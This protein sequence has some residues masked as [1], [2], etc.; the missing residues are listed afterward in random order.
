MKITIQFDHPSPAKKWALLAF[1]SLA[2]LL[3]GGAVAWASGLHVWGTG[4][5]LSATD[6]NGNF[7]YLN[8]QITLLEKQLP[9]PSAF[10][11]EI[12]VAPTTVPTN[13]G[14][15]LLFDSTKFDLNAEYT[16]ATGTFSPKQAGVYFVQC[17]VDWGPTVPTTTYSVAIYDN[18]SEI[19]SS[20]VASAVAGTNNNGDLETPAN[21]IVKLAAGDTVQCATY[22]S[23]GA[24]VT[25]N[26]YSS[27]R[28]FFA[29]SR[30]F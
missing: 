2:L 12:T 21:G 3:G 1:A 6:L 26:N 23:S 15:A 17:S 24:S 30:L 9:T 29:A 14:P 8:D 16:A 27:T 25:L 19:N 22:Q 10:R 13:V 4:D 11:A 7:A 20:A 18:G 28:N 5:K